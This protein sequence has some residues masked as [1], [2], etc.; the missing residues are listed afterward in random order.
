MPDAGRC[1]LIASQAVARRYDEDV[2]IRRAE[3]TDL[4]T[5]IDFN[6]RL[7]IESEGV[8]L[9]AERLRTGVT[10]QLND[11]SRGFYLIAEAD[12]R[13]V[14][15]LALTFEW[16]DWRNATFWWLQNVYVAPEYRRRGVLTALYARVRELAA[17]QGVCGVRLYVEHENHAAQAAYRELGLSPAVYSMYETDFVIE[18]GYDSN[19]AR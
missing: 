8:Q 10:A 9:D 5:I 4:K 17:E 19:P 1:E 13:V 14:G 15:Q 16:S 6:Q 3:P 12:G 7:A 18:R 11:S 2:N